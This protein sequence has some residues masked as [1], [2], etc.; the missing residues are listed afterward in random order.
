MLCEDPGRV[1]RYVGLCPGP[2]TRE[3]PTTP[4]THTTKNHARLALGSVE[5]SVKGLKDSTRGNVLYI[6]MIYM[7]VIFLKRS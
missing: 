7:G 2:P 5:P 3:Y 6:L 4:T 1:G